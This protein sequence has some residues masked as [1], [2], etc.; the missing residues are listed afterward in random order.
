MARPSIRPRN[1][2]LTLAASASLALCA[3]PA[4]AAAAGCDKLASPSGSDSAQGTQAAPYRSVDKLAYS[5]SSGQVG[6]LRGGTYNESLKVSRPGI[7]LRGYDGERAKLVGRLWVDADRVSVERLWLDGTNADGLPSPSVSATDVAFRNNDVTNNHT[8]ICFTLGHAAYGRA[9]RTVIER[10]KIHNCGRLPAN[11]HEHGIYIDTATDARIEGNWIYDNADR[12]IQIYPDSDGAQIK[13][14][15][16]DSNGSGVIFGGAGDTTSDDNVVEGNVI[17]NSKLRH[18]IESYWGETSD[19]GTGNAARSNCVNGGPRDDGNGGIGE[20]LGFVSSANLAKDPAFVNRTGKD[21]RLA[22]DS[23]CR[24]V[25][26]SGDYV[27]GPEGGLNHSSARRARVTLSARPRAFRAGRRVRL[28]GR[29][30]NVAPGRRVFILARR[31]GKWRRVGSARV[32]SNGRYSVKRRIKV[33]RG[34]KA[35][36][37]RAVVKRV[38][39]SRSVKLRIKR[40]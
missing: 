28:A 16:I 20:A 37:L 30:S 39:K 10:N 36:R 6:C 26:G 1:L 22:A 35:V 38:A 12:G 32:R 29:V 24:S 11:N 4:S 5:L 8:T 9:T 31:G 13:G 7:T 14:N 23:P 40:R 34:S 25:Y 33:G 21:Y 17:T 27:P 18:N 2:L 15:V 3:Q 19:I